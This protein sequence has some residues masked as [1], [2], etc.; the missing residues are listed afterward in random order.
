[1]ADHFVHLALIEHNFVGMIR[2]HLAGEANPVGLRQRDDGSDRPMEEIMKMVHKMTEDWASEHRGKSFSA[3]VAVT[4]AGRAE[5]LKLLA[6]LTD[7]Q[8]LEKLPGAPWSDGTIGG[9]LSVNGMHG[10]GHFKW[11]TDGLAKQDA[12]AAAS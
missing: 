1:M 4:L 5:T 3:L 2:R 7:E 12:E 8:L 10:R 6:E 11:A 9:V